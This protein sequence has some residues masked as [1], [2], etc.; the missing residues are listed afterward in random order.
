LPEL[1]CRGL[2]SCVGDRALG[3][4]PISGQRIAVIGT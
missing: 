1:I 3:Q 4:S 2:L